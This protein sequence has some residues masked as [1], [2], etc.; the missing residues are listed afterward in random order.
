MRP[1]L[2]VECAERVSR[3]EVQLYSLATP[4]SVFISAFAERISDRISFPRAAA[5]VRS[6]PPT[7]GAFVCRLL[8]QYAPTAA[9]ACAR[10][11]MRREVHHMIRGAYHDLDLP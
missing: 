4:T 5:V 7:L 9:S 11:N 2:A 6:S 10:N 8:H 3:G 1:E